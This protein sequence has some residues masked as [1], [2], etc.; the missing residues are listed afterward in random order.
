MRFLGSNA[1]E[2][3][4]R[5]GLHPGLRWESFQCSPGLLAGFDGA[6]LRRKRERRGVK[7]FGREGHKEGK[8]WK[9]VE[10]TKLDNNSNII[11]I[12]IYLLSNHIKQ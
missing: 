11:I 12:I 5:P 3:R 1:T 9:V 2:M 8:K 4:W 6:A 10:N 7:R